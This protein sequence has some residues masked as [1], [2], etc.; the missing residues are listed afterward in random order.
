MNAQRDI[1][2]EKT[3]FDVMRDVWRAKFYILVFSFFFLIAAFAFMAVAQKYYRATMIV[4]PALPMGGFGAPDTGEGSAQVQSETLHSNA[5]FLQFENIYSGVSVAKILMDDPKVMAQIDMDR[6]F[7]FS[8]VQENWTAESLSEYL[9]Q[10]VILSPVSGTPL[11]SIVYYHPDRAFAK[12]MVG[13][14]H[15]IADEIIRA[16]VLKETSQ[17]IDYLQQALQG[18]QNPDHKRSLTAL[19]ME[20]ERARMMV[21]MDQPF[22]ARVIEFPHVSANPKWPDPYFIYPVFLLVGA[23]LGF[24]V[25]GLRQNAK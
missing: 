2:L 24:V 11:R 14:V 17:R 1:T 7:E 5:A 3:L 21:S 13:R 16:R 8:N 25:Y 18:A 23:F 4:A 22:S 20:Q 10:H 19:L 12:D 15:R 9:R 6:P